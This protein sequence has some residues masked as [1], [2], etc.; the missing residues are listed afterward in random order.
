MSEQV[1]L[2]PDAEGRERFRAG[3]ISLAV[4]LALLLVKYAAY[5]LTGSAAVLSDALES[6]I[7]VV[8]AAFAMASLAFAARPADSNHPYGHGKMEFFSAAFEGGLIAFAALA[9][10]WYAILDLIRGPEL[11]AIEVG[12]ALT[13]GAGVVNA[14]LGLFLIRT[15]RR[16][17]SLTLVAD[18]QHVLSDFW[19]S[20]GVVV[21][22]GLVRVTGWVW[23]DPV[24]ALVVGA[25][26]GRTGLALVRHAAGGLLD[27][28]DTELLGRIVAAFDETR[29]P[30]IIRIHRLRA[31]RA[32]RFTH[33]DAHLVLP[34]YWTI[35]RAHEVTDAYEQ[36]VMDAC[37][38]DG[39]I[40]FHNDPC[41]R[42]L[43]S[44][45][46]VPDCPIRRADFE[47]RPPLSLEEA[48]QTDESFWGARGYAMPAPT[49]RANPT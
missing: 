16:T 31:I 27:E 37:N 29:T 41:R 39:E 48:R 20:F 5:R 6:I 42:L 18:G 46:D 40:V 30:G 1:V 45:C 10:I 34:E 47:T 13:L 43:C 23:L 3:A 4:G 22:L 24:V 44:A 19:T 35:E 17:R 25:N 21:G 2:S 11:K 14:A 8:A 32:G 33:V 36:R 26:L 12:A 49:T 15:G 7:N 28:E 38:I 9:I